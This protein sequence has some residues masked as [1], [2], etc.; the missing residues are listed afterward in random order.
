VRNTRWRGRWQVDG[1]RATTLNTNTVPEDPAVVAAVKEQHATTVAYVNRVVA[2]CAVELSS[3]ESRYR[4]TPIVDYVNRV[5][6]D[7]VAAALADGPHAGLPVLSVVA[8]YRRT[9]CLP[10]GEVRIRDV[11]GFYVFDNPLEA[12]LITGAELRAYLEHSARYFRTLAPGDPV[13]PAMISDPSVRDYNYDVV[14]GVDYDID[15]SRPV[16]TRITHLA[17]EGHPVDPAQ[18][19][20]VAVNSYRRGGGGNFPGIVKPPVFTAE[21]EIRQLL[22]DWARARGGIDPTDFFRPNWRLVR[23]GVPLFE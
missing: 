5:Q 22:I 12:V 14:S 8:P 23:A 18:C 3:A 10:A 16:G 19:F 21:R 11:A 2:R 4:A 1:A 6:T 20:V 13:D 15:V 17:A 7:T 9:A